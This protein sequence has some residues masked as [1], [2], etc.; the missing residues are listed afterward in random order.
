MA[1]AS[2]DDDLA[3]TSALQHFAFCE[4]QC[5]LIHLER[6]WTENDLTAE[7]RIVHERVDLPGLSGR[8]RI[9]RAVQLRCERLGL[10]GR[11]DVVEFLPPTELGGREIPFPVEYKRGR[12]VERL[13]DRVQLCAQAMALEEMT[14]V[15]VPRGAVFYHASRRRVAVEFDAELRR[16]T[17]VLA[18]RL[19]A[20][21]TTGVVPRA[22]LQPKCRR[23]SLQ[24]A[25]QPTR[26]DEGNPTTYLADLVRD[27]GGSNPP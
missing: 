14:G 1:G 26:P 20:M 23:C 3:P 22:G 9:A 12:T 15:M 19:H 17:E 24:E 4:R 18:G 7:G 27:G 21:L 6:V 16:E 13:P 25:C 5:A 2:E 8:G 10:A 11:A